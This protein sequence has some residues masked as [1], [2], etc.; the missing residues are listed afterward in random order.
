MG[1]ASCACEYEISVQRE[2][3]LSGA[4]SVYSELSCEII[5]AANEKFYREGFAKCP[6]WLA[7]P[8]KLFESVAAAFFCFVLFVLP[9]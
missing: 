2:E 8:A 5:N 3:R 6:L 1:T 7:L 4:Q 9:A